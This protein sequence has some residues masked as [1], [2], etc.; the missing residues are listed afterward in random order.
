MSAYGTKV[1]AVL[2]TQ[3]AFGVTIKS[4]RDQVQTLQSDLGLLSGSSTPGFITRLDAAEAA[5]VDLET[6]VAAL[7]A[8]DHSHGNSH[9]HTSS[10]APSSP[11]EGELWFNISTLSLNIYID[12]GTSSQWVQ[13]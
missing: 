1:V 12:D 13:L 4:L 3:S 8:T 6:R 2:D 10:V 9:V 7:E 11:V 5:I